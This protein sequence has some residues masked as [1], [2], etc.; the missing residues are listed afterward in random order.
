MKSP[1]I[2]IVRV[3]F[4]YMALRPILQ[5]LTLRVV[6]GEKIALIGDTGA[7][8]TCIARL[9][10]GELIPASGEVR[11]FG[12]PLQYRSR[13]LRHH[14]I[15]TPLIDQHAT[16]LLPFLTI[17]ENVM[18][19]L[20]LRGVGFTQAKRT[21]SLLLDRVGIHHLAEARGSEISGGERQRAVISR[22]LA[23]EGEIL[24]ADEP[25]GALDAPTARSILKL[26]RD[27]DQT[28]L[29]ITHQPSLA[30]CFF[31]R[32]LLLRDG[33]LYDVTQTAVINPELLSTF[34]DYG[35]LIDDPA[36]DR[37]PNDFNRRVCTPKRKPLRCG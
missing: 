10:R 29:L 24:L 18:K 30:A 20:Q 9:V 32:L 17:L 7:G 28:V 23:Q 34:D 14:W 36:T 3:C 12:H 8:K 6:P 4:A 27:L 15:K 22:A 26:L 16:T 35:E 13:C 33:R 21:G 25:T 2:E 1:I 19:P 11:A 37:M 5:D 31:D